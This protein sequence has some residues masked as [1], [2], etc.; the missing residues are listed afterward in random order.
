M[1][2]ED[3][4]S[5]ALGHLMHS[6][7]TYKPSRNTRRR[8]ASKSS[9]ELCLRS[10]RSPRPMRGYEPWRHARCGRGSELNSI[11]CPLVYISTATCGEWPGSKHGSVRSHHCADRKVAQ[12]SPSHHGL[13]HQNGT[14]RPTLVST[15][16]QLSHQLWHK[17]LLKPCFPVC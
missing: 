12:T 14:K 8:R 13:N 4:F 1:Q 3:T 5:S 2:K 9:T 7:S 10:Q 15:T 11:S 16:R 6:Y 17:N